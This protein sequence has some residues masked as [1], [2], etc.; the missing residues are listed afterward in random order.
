MPNKWK[1]AREQ[2]A[3]ANRGMQLQDRAPSLR[4]CPECGLIEII[5]PCRNCNKPKCAVCAANCSVKPSRASGL[6]E[7]EHRDPVI[8]NRDPV[9][10]TP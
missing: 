3:L 7:I 9:G 5:K 4:H 10:K 6:I 1:A 2:K 8:R